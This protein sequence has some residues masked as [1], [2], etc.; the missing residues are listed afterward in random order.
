VGGKTF[1]INNLNKRQAFQDIQ[2]ALGNEV[3]FT[4]FTY[5]LANTPFY[6]TNHIILELKENISISQVLQMSA[7]DDV[8]HSDIIAL[9][10]K[11]T[12]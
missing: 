9:S 10:P 12:S 7:S 2:N 8:A 4:S 1:I 3:E 6:P 11:K 5:K